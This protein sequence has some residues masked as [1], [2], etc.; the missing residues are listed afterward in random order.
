MVQAFPLLIS[1]PFYLYVLCDVMIPSV[2]NHTTQYPICNL[3]P[4]SPQK[5]KQRFSLNIV[6]MSLVGNVAVYCC[7]RKCTIKVACLL[8]SR[9]PKLTEVFNY[10]K[11]NAIFQTDKSFVNYTQ[12]FYLAYTQYGNLANVFAVYLTSTSVNYVKQVIK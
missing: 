10:V 9:N 8:F 12:T 3:S 5:N 1:P 4:T 7:Y 2:I 11:R 6:F